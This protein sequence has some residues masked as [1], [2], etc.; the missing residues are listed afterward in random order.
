M[1]QP[2]LPVVNEVFITKTLTFCA[3][4]C[5]QGESAASHA[6]M[7]AIVRSSDP[8]TS[9]F[10]EEFR[11]RL[12]TSCQEDIGE[13]QNFEEIVPLATRKGQ[14]KVVCDTMADLNIFTPFDL[15]VK[16]PLTA[17]KGQSF[18]QHHSAASCGKT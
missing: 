17:S 9:P 7:T 2:G 8:G 16:S 15:L 12:D 4:L 1:K 13:E 5:D 11:K 14:A 18:Y 10:H 3:L 6:I